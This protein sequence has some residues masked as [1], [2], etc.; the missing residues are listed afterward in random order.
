MS[1][2][3][4][5]AA[6]REAISS[7]GVTCKMWWGYKGWGWDADVLLGI[8]SYCLLQGQEFPFQI[9]FL[10]E[11]PKENRLQDLPFL[12]AF[13]GLPHLA[14]SYPMQ[15]LALPRFWAASAGHDVGIKTGMWAQ[16]SYEVLPSAPL[17]QS[18]LVGREVKLIVLQHLQHGYI[19]KPA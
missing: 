15:S 14:V 5:T 1:D 12:L 7:P 16:H 8:A 10:I 13:V 17:L 11:V 2:G 19:C 9:G 3:W 4:A 6:W 18:G